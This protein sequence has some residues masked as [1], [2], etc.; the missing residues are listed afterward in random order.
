VR[1][2]GSVPW[3]TVRRVVI[4]IAPCP[5]RPKEEGQRRRG[6]EERTRIG[7][8]TQAGAG[9][10]THM[11]DATTARGTPGCASPNTCPPQCVTL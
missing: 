11:S 4:S 9:P 8:T 3:I 7:G 10:H 2:R 5:I 6:E 1:E